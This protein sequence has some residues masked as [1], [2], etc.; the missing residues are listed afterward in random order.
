MS[1]PLRQKLRGEFCR[2][3]L[4]FMPDASKLHRHSSSVPNQLGTHNATVKTRASFLLLYLKSESS[5]TSTTK[6]DCSRLPYIKPHN[7]NR[8]W[9]PYSV[10][11][12]FSN[13]RLHGLIMDASIKATWSY[14]WKNCAYEAGNEELSCKYMNVAPDRVLKVVCII[15][16]V[17][18]VGRVPRIIVE[19][20]STGVILYGAAYCCSSAHISSVKKNE[21]L[22]VLCITSVVDLIIE[23]Y[24]PGSCIVQ[25]SA[26]TK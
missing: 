22:F 6:R 26:T 4:H 2:N 24:L 18:A 12:R 1:A 9:L 15:S 11:G 13:I 8:F 14:S 23:H 3:C 21:L 16:G 10:G 5:D 19:H 7:D 17:F 25:T 20:C